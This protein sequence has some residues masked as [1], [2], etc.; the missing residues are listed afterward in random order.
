MPLQLIL[1]LLI[2]LALLLVTVQNPNPV[3]LPFLSWQARQ[4]PLIIIILISLL[5]GLI[6]SSI[7]GL[8]KQWKLKGTIGRLQREI[9][10]MKQPPVV[11]Q[12]EDL[13][14]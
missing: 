6:V 14:D 5:A 2:A 7:L 13:Q 4:I 12:D 10:E 1:M 9:E 8:L 11:P 3:S